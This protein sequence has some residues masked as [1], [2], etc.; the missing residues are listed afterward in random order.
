M[1]FLFFHQTT[2]GQFERVA[3]RLAAEPGNRVLCLGRRPVSETLPGLEVRTYEIDGDPKANPHRFLR[4]ADLAVRH[5]EGIARAAM[6]LKAEGFRPDVMIGHAGWGE[7][8]YL[9]DVWPD[10]PLVSYFEYYYDGRGLLA[11]FDRAEPL[12]FD[13]MMRVRT[14]NAVNLMS[15]EAADW[16][17]SPMVWQRLQYPAHYRDRISVIHDGVDTARARPDPAQVVRLAD[18][19][20]LRAGEEIVTYVARGLEPYRGFPVFMRALPE[21]L[22]R[23]PQARVVVVGSPQTAYN[24]PLPNGETYLARMLA[25]LGDRLPRERVSFLGWVPFESYLG[26]LRVS[27][28]HVYL[29]HPFVLSWSMM[30]AMASGCVLVGSATPPVEEVVRHGVN[31]FLCEFGSPSAVA[32]TVV[33]ALARRAELGPIRAAARQTI[34][35]GY[36]LERVSL[37]RYR[38]L[39]EAIASGRRPQ[40]YDTPTH[41]RPAA[42]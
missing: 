7:G 29:T 40:T 8:L 37:P 41:D 17:I 14:K 24:S 36:D 9:K 26:L 19:T 18:G 16:G 27:A 21:I 32:D 42:A 2:P 20:V 28:A 10:V 25:E 12:P 15:L 31:G 11:G 22:A 39:I 33:E 1:H 38:T 23:R 13:D 6:A 4:E 34:V 35:D 3:T 30:E 5:G